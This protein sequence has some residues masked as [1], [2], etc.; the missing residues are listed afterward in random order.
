M[1]DGRREHT[2]C[3]SHVI[4]PVLYTKPLLSDPSVTSS[5]GSHYIFFFT[6]FGEI[7]EVQFIDSVHC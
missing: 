3:R 2:R 6:T 5:L 7:G 4:G 1:E